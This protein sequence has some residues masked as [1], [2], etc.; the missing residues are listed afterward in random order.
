[1][2]APHRARPV[3]DAPALDGAAVA[4]A[5]LV[6]LV[7]RA[8]LDRA[9][10]LPGPRFAEEAPAL[11]S[12]ITAALASDA[13]LD[14]VATGGVN[15]AA[16]AA[17][18]TPSEAVAALEALRA[19]LWAEILAALDRPGPAQVGDLAERL[20]AVVATLTTAV[21]EAPAGPRPGARSGPLAA[22]LRDA[23]HGAGE[24]E[25]GA[26]HEASAE[27][28]PSVGRSD[29]DP[30]VA[31]S[32]P[33]PSAG[34]P[35]GDRREADPFPASPADGGEAGRS[36]DEGAG[37]V[38]DLPS[39]WARGPERRTGSR[40]PREWPAPPPG[41][42]VV[43]DAFAGVPERDDDDR[44]VPVAAG[45]ERPTWDDGDAALLA[46]PGAGRGT[47][48]QIE[49]T[50]RDAATAADP[51]AAAAERL[52]HLALDVPE[53]EPTVRRGPELED[54]DVS[55]VL[56]WTAA[57]QRRLDRHAVD[58]L[59]FAVLCLELADLDRLVAADRDRDV[60]ATL[61]AAEAAILTRLRPADG[62]VRER[63]GRYWLTAP[64]TGADDA[65]ALAL[66][67]AAAINELPPH[68]GTPLEVAIGVTSCP[69]DAADAP[70]LESL[71]EE[72]L[73]AA[74]AAGVRVS[75]A[76]R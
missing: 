73:C 38:H 14:D 6:E 76:P 64:D 30:T 5:W 11:C 1:M 71:A 3:A 56:P 43:R 9:A 65:R 61:E 20:S 53:A 21:L 31:R 28:D 12:A 27:A 69:A 55:R 67:I 32:D 16:L 74:R 24:E 22:V 36:D 23:R 51:L 44:A 62:L 13:A 52:R 60:L 17:A 45:S 2:T 72:G 42:P 63:T 7:A 70:T 66:R 15:A 40:A 10:R 29:P 54:A 49:A 33:D 59:P 25:P 58:G 19:V 37:E 26:D 41:V 39:R 35:S 47:L 4:K 68:R 57:I 8:P 34:R 46:E 18:S 50:L 75:S 48:A